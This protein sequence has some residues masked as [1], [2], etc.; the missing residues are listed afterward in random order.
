MTTNRGNRDGRLPIDPAVK[1]DEGAPLTRVKSD[2]RPVGTPAS[3]SVTPSDG[4]GTAGGASG[5]SGGGSRRAT[6]TPPANRREGIAT[7]VKPQ[8][9]S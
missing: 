4:S 5:S 7:S 2:R 1:Q 6:R 3:D 8:G 9:T